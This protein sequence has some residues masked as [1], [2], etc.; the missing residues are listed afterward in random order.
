MAYCKR[1][2]LWE[3]SCG[4]QGWV[5]TFWSFKRRSMLTWLN[6]FLPFFSV[7]NIE[8]L[9]EASNSELKALKNFTSIEKK[10]SSQIIKGPHLG[11]EV[12][13]AGAS[14]WDPQSQVRKLEVDLMVTMAAHLPTCPWVSA[15]LCLAVSTHF[16]RDMMYLHDRILWFSKLSGMFYS[17]YVGGTWPWR[18]SSLP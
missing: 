13:K 17:Q 15:F 10:T 11:W 12:R 4:L 9:L 5:F 16:T 6:S 3:I 2:K 8:H 18:P 7:L 1:A 14:L